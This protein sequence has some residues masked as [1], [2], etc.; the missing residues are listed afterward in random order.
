M[1]G[2]NNFRKQEPKA[3]IGVE[4]WAWFS[5]LS[6]GSRFARLA[7]FVDRFAL[8]GFEFGRGCRFDWVGSHQIEWRG[9]LVRR[10]D[11]IFVFYD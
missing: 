1:S 2:G 9:K 3:A 10:R 6:P 7:L 11:C 4:G 8:P 5:I